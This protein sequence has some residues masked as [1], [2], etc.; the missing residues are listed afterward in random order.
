M[1]TRPSSAQVLLAIRKELLD[2]VL[3]A[4]T[5]EQAR[6]AIQMAENLLYSTAQRGDEVA[7]M[8]AEIDT[9]VEHAA[10][11]VAAGADR[12]GRIAG[13]LAEFEAARSAGVDVASVRTEYDA[14]SELLSLCIEAT[15]PVGGELHAASM[16]VLQQRLDRELEILGEFAFVGRG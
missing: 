2:V 7:F 8:R 4:V 1:I 6:I 11:V 14:A 13:P 12:S 5:T 3:P 9:V 10:T 15:M 16:A